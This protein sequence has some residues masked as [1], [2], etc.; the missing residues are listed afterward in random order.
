MAF[1]RANSSEGGAA[2]PPRRMTAPA[3]SAEAALV[4]ERLA[5]V[6][7]KLQGKVQ[8]LALMQQLLPVGRCS[9]C[10]RRAAYH[11]AA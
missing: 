9:C 7:Q 4:H 1:V 6:V 5:E 3:A 10:R 11:T 8:Q 2:S